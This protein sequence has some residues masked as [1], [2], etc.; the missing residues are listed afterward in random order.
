[1]YLAFVPPKQNVTLKKIHDFVIVSKIYIS[2]LGGGLMCTICYYFYSGEIFVFSVNFGN[3][4][5]TFEFFW[6]GEFCETLN[7]SKL[8]KRP[9]L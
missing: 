2:L 1:M 4:S 5:K 7:H 8:E 6:L 3:F 9:C